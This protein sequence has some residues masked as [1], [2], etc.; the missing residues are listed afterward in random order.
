MT[1][2]NHRHDIPTAKIKDERN[3]NKLYFRGVL[4]VCLCFEILQSFKKYEFYNALIYLLKQKS[5]FDFRN[6]RFFS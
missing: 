6:K 2:K 1:G 4:F 3:K 5:N